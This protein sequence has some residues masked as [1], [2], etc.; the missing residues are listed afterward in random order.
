M[1][2]TRN[3]IEQA[4]LTYFSGK[5]VKSVWLFGSY[6]R[7]EAGENSDVDFLIDFQPGSKVGLRY[8]AWPEELEAL[9]HKKVQVVSRSAV[10]DR[11]RFF[12]DA[13]KTLLYERPDC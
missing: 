10:P 6:A 8:L 9:V 13:D 1:I 5:P 4:A 2:L 11:I 12:I 7:G 3:E